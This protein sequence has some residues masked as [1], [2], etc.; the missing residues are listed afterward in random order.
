M[1]LSPPYAGR[2]RRCSPTSWSPGTTRAGCP[3]GD[4]PT[5]SLCTA[6]ASSCPREGSRRN[7]PGSSSVSS[8]GLP[9]C[10]EEKYRAQ[11]TQ[12]QK[13]VF[14]L[15]REFFCYFLAQARLHGDGLLPVDSHPAGP[16]QHRAPPVRD[17]PGLQGAPVLGGVCGRK[18]GLL[19]ALER[20]PIRRMRANIK[21]NSQFL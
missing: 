14:N 12:Q 18:G 20:V 3:T 1:K 21:L 10:E 8:S 17:R 19:L 11:C 4:G 16:A 2:S 15:S 5:S 6:R 7:S 9:N 13:I